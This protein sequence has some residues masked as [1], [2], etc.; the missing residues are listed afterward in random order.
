M[1]KL[2]KDELR[3]HQQALDLLAK[4]KLSFDDKLFVLENWH[5][6]A[7]NLNSAAGAFFTPYYLARDFNLEIYE[8]DNHLI[9][10]CAGI[11]ALSLPH[12]TLCE[13]NYKES[14]ITCIELNPNYIEVGKKILPK[15]KWVQMSALDLDELKKL[16]QFNQVISNPPFG[17]IKT[18]Q[19]VDSENELKYKGSEFEFKIMEIGSKI[20]DYGSFLVPQNSTPFK[21]SGAHYYED[22]RTEDNGSRLSSK[23]K[24]FIKETNLHFQ[25]GVGVDTSIYLDDWKGVKPLCE[26]VNFDYKEDI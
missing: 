9:D 16:G 15:A 20:A 23:V 14:D 18:A 22:L 19:Y 7:E 25:F 10:L 8:D 11:G 12:Y 2:T 24:K 4:D 21:Y 26:V 3:K 13:Y 6:G 1:A 17:K 5:E